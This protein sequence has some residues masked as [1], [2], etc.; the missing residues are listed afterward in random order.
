MQI[1]MKLCFVSAI[2]PEHTLKQALGFAH[3]AGF[4]SVQLT[5]WPPGIA[6]R[7]YSG[8]TH[9]DATDLS[10]DAGYA[11]DVA[12]EIEDRAIEGSLE[13]RLNALQISRRYLLEYIQG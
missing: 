4:S 13:S 11:G 7:R 10:M 2:H 1:S 12:I 3:N 6:N 9:I 8:V 5:C